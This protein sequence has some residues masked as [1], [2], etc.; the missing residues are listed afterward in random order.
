MFF[1]CLSS[2]L[3]K[4]NFKYQELKLNKDKIKSLTV[5]IIFNNN[6][7]HNTMKK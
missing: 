1:C 7:I 4:I 3:N 2:L 6:C 5:T